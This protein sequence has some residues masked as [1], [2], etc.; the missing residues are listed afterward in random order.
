[1]SIYELINKYDLLKLNKYY[2]FSGSRK[3]NTVYYK[4]FYNA[5]EHVNHNMIYNGNSSTSYPVSLTD[6]NGILVLKL[7]ADF[8]INKILEIKRDLF[9][10][11]NGHKLTFINGSYIHIVNNP[12]VNSRFDF[13]IYGKK[14]GS[15]IIS[16][17]QYV[18]LNDNIN[19]ECQLFEDYEY[20][21]CG[22]NLC[23]NTDNGFKANQFEGVNIDE[24]IYTHL[25]YNRL[26]NPIENKSYTVN[27]NYKL[28][29]IKYNRIYLIDCIINHNP[30]KLANDT[31]K[32]CLTNYRKLVSTIRSEHSYVTIKRCNITLTSGYYWTD[33][34]SLYMS[35]NVN[36]EDSIISTI[37]L[38]SVFSSSLYNIT[39]SVCCLSG[40]NINL[41][42]NKIYTQSVLSTIC[43]VSIINVSNANLINNN[44]TTNMTQ[45][46]NSGY[47][48]KIYNQKDSLYNCH[49]KVVFKNN[50]IEGC[51]GGIGILN[52]NEAYYCSGRSVS[53]NS[54]HGG[55]YVSRGSNFYAMGGILGVSKIHKYPGASGMS[56]FS[57]GANVFLN[58][59]NFVNEDNHGTSIA[60]VIKQGEPNTGITTVHCSNCRTNG[61]LIR[62]DSPHKLILGKKGLTL[63]NGTILGVT[64]HKK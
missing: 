38:H 52:I 46:A 36:I 24:L 12:L 2:N 32:D 57:S 37:N 6:V 17:S 51:A 14:S 18:I 63:G 11:L 29:G 1:M 42:N 10:D 9:I 41:C 62:V 20:S 25:G 26:F 7:Y 15:E 56:Y 54:G 47:G 59:V 58:N 33:T 27:R 4:D 19:K 35:S 34:I 44:I 8:T 30:N 50:N 40:D 64:K 28:F 16:T 48:V 49:T 31:D 60:F 13:A 39:N 5:I 22:H 55:V 53:W 61:Q 43:S 3:F 45:Y 23:T 21:E